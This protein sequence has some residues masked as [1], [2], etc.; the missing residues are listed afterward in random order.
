MEQAALNKKSKMEVK[1]AGLQVWESKVAGRDG[2]SEHICRI[3]GGSM[4][5]DPAATPVPWADT[6]QRVS[7]ATVHL[8]FPTVWATQS[9]MVGCNRKIPMA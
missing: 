7:Q 8:Q 5:L 3:W 6:C 4:S 1:E 9:T 2:G